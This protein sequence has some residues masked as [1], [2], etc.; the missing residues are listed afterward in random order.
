[1]VGALPLPIPDSL[2]GGAGP[3]AG[4]PALKNINIFYTLGA[5]HWVSFAVGDWETENPI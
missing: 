2:A 3:N 4:L 1:M 5:L